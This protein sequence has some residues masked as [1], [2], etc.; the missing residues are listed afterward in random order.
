MAHEAGH[1]MGLNDR[2]FEFQ[3]NPR[4]TEPMPGWEKNIMARSLATLIN[5]IL[6][7][8]FMEMTGKNQNTV[9]RIETDHE[10]KDVQTGGLY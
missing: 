6:I 1:L 3:K 2:Y 7:R 9:R 10:K 8:L 5:G 4:K